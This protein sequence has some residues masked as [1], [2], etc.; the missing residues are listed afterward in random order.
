MIELERRDDVFVLH[1]RGGENRFNRSFLSELNR[2][3]DQVEKSSPPAALVTTG[4]GKFYSNGLD[5]AWLGGEG[6][7]RAGPFLAEVHQLFAR[8]LSFPTA[9]VAA[10]NGHAFAGGGML[11]LAHDFR[12]MRADRGYFCLP[13]IDL[14][15]PLQPGMTA[16]IRARLSA[17][18]AHEAI[19]TGR[20]YGGEEA[21]RVGIADEAVPEEQVLPRAVERAA[22]LADKDRTTLAALK[23]GLYRTTLAILRGEAQG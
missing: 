6:S 11:A 2:A 20:R 8:V 22:A 18:T 21:T 1:L 7:D 14:G 9:T 3:L 15:L 17:A 5:L 10:V 19:V 4:E 12:V 16:I 23:E 13:E